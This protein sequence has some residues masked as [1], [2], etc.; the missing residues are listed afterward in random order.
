MFRI[1]YITRCGQP[2]RGVFGQLLRVTADIPDPT[3]AAD[4]RAPVDAA[5][6]AC[7]Y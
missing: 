1:S 7:A 4:V 3:S 6:A 2:L 5:L